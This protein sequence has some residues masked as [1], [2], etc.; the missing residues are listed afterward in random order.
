MVFSTCT[1]RKKE[2]E[3]VLSSFLAVR[4]DFAPLPFTV[5]G[6]SAPDGRLTLFPDTHGTDGFFIAK[7][8][9]KK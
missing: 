4:P 3:D 2:N 5:G 9:R 7:L 6:L 1:L 8:R